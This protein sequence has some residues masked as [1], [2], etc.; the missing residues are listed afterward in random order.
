MEQ[1]TEP[2]TSGQPQTV[3]PPV[4][5]YYDRDNDVVRYRVGATWGP[6]LTRVEANR[7]GRDLSDAAFAGTFIEAGLS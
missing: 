2:T 4:F 5:A 1:P 7:L 6:E 3:E